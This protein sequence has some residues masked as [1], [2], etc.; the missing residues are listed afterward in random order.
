MIS[1]VI[2]VIA[3]LVGIFVVGMVWYGPLFGKKWSTYTGI[4]ENDKDMKKNMLKYMAQNQVVSLIWVCA[5]AYIIAMWNPQ[6]LSQL[7]VLIVLLWLAFT[8][9]SVMS[10]NIWER[11]P[12]GLGILSMF[13]DLA[14]LLVGGTILMILL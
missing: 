1:Y 6:N 8:V 5:L 10:S 12:L 4:K 13:G 3:A 9:P 11:K 7:M 2:A 14:W